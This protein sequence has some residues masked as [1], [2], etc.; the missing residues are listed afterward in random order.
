MYQLILLR[1]FHE[2]FIFLVYLIFINENN[3]NWQ[4]ISR[5]KM[6]F[7]ILDPIKINF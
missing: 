2:I 1:L 4:N 5:L 7:D 6:K 3:W